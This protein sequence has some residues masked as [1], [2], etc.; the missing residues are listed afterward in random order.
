MKSNADWHRADEVRRI[1]M[2]MTMISVALCISVAAGSVLAW[3]QLKKPPAEPAAA[4]AKS[5]APVSPVSSALPEYG[6]EYDLLL[7]NSA[8][9][10]KSDFTVI[11]VDFE[12]IQVDGRILPALQKMMDDAKA[13]GCPLKLTGGYVS[14]QQQNQLFRAAVQNMMKQKGLSQVRAENDAQNLVGK[15]G[16]NE[17]QTGMAVTFSAPGLAPNTKFSSTA[18]YNWLMKH[19]VTYGFILRYPENKSGITGKDFDAQHFRYVG[20]DNAVKMREYGM[21]LEEYSSYLQQQ[22]TN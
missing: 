4:S 13:D 14:P 6:N 15:A 10:L 11:P 9:P 22:G 3:M 18:Q 12:G 16:Y 1:R 20:S 7:V 2:V 19:S 5:S 8:N 21:C 17:N